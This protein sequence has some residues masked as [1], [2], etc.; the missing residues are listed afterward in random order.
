VLKPDSRR[1]GELVPLRAAT[2]RGEIVL[3][4]PRLEP[5]TAAYY[6]CSTRYKYGPDKC[7]G[8]RLSKDRLEDAVLTQLASIYRDTHLIERALADAAERAEREQP[9]LEDALA[10]CRPE[11]ARTECK[12]DR[13][14]DAFESGKLSAADCQERLHR[15]K[16]R[17]ETLREQEADLARRLATHADEPPDAGPLAELADQLDDVIA[18]ESPEQAK[19]LLRLLVKEIRVHNRRRILPIYRVPAA[20]RAIPRKVGGTGLEPVTPSLSSWCSPN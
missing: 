18:S 17:L 6:T 9:P 12:L 19:D 5:L 15:H 11:I 20:V 1:G 10:G 4:R 8:D 2:D 14:Y 3:E 7:N 16:G 13:Y